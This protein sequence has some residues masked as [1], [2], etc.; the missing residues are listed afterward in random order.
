VLDP[1]AITDVAV[2][3]TLGV[4]LASKPAGTAA[5]LISWEPG[6][7]V[8][9]YLD[10]GVDDDELLRLA[11]RAKNV[12]IDVPFGWPD[13]FVDSVSA[14][15][16]RSSWP[17]VSQ[18]QLRYRRTDLFVWQTTG[19]PP[20]SVSSDLLAIPAF[21]LASHLARWNADRT[22]EGKYV[23]VYPRAARNRWNLET[24]RVS[25]IAERA[26]WL[27]LEPEHVTSCDDDEDCYDAL[28]AALVTRAHVLGK[29][30]PIPNEELD[31]ARR[32]GW[33]ALPAEG[34]LERLV[35]HVSRVG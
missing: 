26:P 8:I 28:V 11:D 29:C 13:A 30:E 21:R 33:I 27:R 32:E 9:E 1:R 4:D 10:A 24:K 14:H 7:A 19:R 34:S 2:S 18:R 5:C 6:E 22:G 20:L 35:D 3:R 15:R 31:A 23:E 17:S 25:E 16:D 12:G